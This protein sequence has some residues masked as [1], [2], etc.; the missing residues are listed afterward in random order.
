[1]PPLFISDQAEMGILS[2]NRSEWSGKRQEVRLGC[3]SPGRIT[4]FGVSEPR[5]WCR[6][7]PRRPVMER[8]ESVNRSQPIDREYLR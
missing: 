5:R 3:G 8:L 6:N 1:M 2:K 4:S 7:S